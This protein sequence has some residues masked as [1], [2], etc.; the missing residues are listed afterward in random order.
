MRSDFS[1]N[2][3]IC[4]LCNVHH[5]AVTSSVKIKLKAS[6]PSEHPTQ[7]GKTSKRLG[8]MIGC[9]DKTSSYAPDGAD[10]KV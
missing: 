6:R 2:T 3:S 10:A 4:S 9:I 8:G 1:L 7:G 5:T